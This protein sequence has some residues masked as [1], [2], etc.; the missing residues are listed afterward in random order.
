MLS[1]VC[2]NLISPGLCCL[3]CCGKHFGDTVGAG[4]SMFIS[5]LIS[6]MFC[7]CKVQRQMLT[8]GIRHVESTE[9]K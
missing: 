4:F 5:N 6:W 1:E 9:A 2:V 8:V 7:C 3:V